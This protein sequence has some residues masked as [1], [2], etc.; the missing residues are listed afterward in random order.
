MIGDRAAC[1]V[2][3][4]VTLATL[5]ACLWVAL[6]IA[7]EDRGGLALLLVAGVA[8]VCGAALKGLHDAWRRRSR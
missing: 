3:T 5:V 7:E 2:L 4:V 8:T 6:G 1:V